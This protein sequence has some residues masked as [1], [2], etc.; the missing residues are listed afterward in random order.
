[1]VARL[2]VHGLREVAVAIDVA[3]VRAVI[4]D[5]IVVFLHDGL[6]ALELLFHSLQVALLLVVALHE[7]AH[8]VGL[9]LTVGLLLVAQRVNG[10]PVALSFGFLVCHQLLEHVELDSGWV[11][12]LDVAV[13]LGHLGLLFRV[14]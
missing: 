2:L 13:R 7:F 8:H 6:S 11:R 3:V 5:L 1:M 12:L 10:L 4:V 14:G 9:P